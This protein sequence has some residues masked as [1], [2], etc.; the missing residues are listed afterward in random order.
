MQQRN[1]IALTNSYL[2]AWAGPWGVSFATNITPDME[3]GIAEWEEST[4]HQ[5]LRTGEHQ[6]QP[7]A[8]AILLPMPWPTIGLATDKDL[9]SIWAS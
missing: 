8:R 2:T 9:K 5:A 1:T 6:G 4:F 3:T 7:N